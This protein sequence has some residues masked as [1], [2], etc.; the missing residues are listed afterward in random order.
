MPKVFKKAES[1]TTV[2]FLPD[3]SPEQLE[4]IEQTFY[5]GSPKANLRT[6]APGSYVTPD[7]ETAKLM[8]RFHVDTGKTWSDDDLIGKHYFGNQPT[9]KPGKEPTGDATIYK[10]RVAIKKL[11]LLN[12]PY[13]HITLGKLPVEKLPPTFSPDYTP[14]QLKEKLLSMAKL[15]GSRGRAKPT[16]INM[17]KQSDIQ[18]VHYARIK[19]DA[20]RTLLYAELLKDRTNGRWENKPELASKYVE[21]RKET[22]RVYREKLKA[23]GVN[24]PE[25]QS[26]LY[27]TIPGREKFNPGKGYYPHNF[28]INDED[29]KRTLFDVVGLPDKLLHP[30]GPQLGQAGYDDAIARWDKHKKILGK[31]KYMGMTINPRIEVISPHG[32][33]GYANLMKQSASFIPD[34]TPEQLREMEQP[35]EGVRA[36]EPIR[37]LTEREK[38][39]LL[40]RLSSKF[41]VSVH[42]SAPGKRVMFHG[43]TPQRA[44]QIKAKGL[45]IGSEQNSFNNS[46]LGRRDER[47]HNFWTPDLLY[48][49][50]YGAMNDDG[51]FDWDRKPAVFSALLDESSLEKSPPEGSLAFGPVYSADSFLNFANIPPQDLTDVF[52]EKKKA[53]ESSFLP[54]YTPE[55]LKEMGVYKEVYG[56]KDAPRLA[57]LPAW[58]EHWYNEADPHGWLQWY[59]RYSSG[60][61]IEDDKRQIKRWIA[62][63]AR[64]GGK[65]FKDNPTPRRAFALRNWGIDASKLVDDPETLKTVMDEYKTNKYNQK[66]EKVSFLPNTTGWPQGSNG[67]LGK[68][69]EAEFPGVSH[70]FPGVSES[71]R[72]SDSVGPGPNEDLLKRITQITQGSTQESNGPLGKSR[73]AE[74][75][76]VSHKFPEGYKPNYNMPSFLPNK[77]LTTMKKSAGKQAGAWR[78]LGKALPESSAS[79]GKSITPVMQKAL[80]PHLADE[81][82]LNRMIYSL[83]D[84]VLPTG[85]MGEALKSYAAK[86]DGAFSPKILGFALDRAERD[87]KGLTEFVTSNSKLGLKLWA[88]EK[89]ARWYDDVL[90]SM[91]ATGPGH[92]AVVADTMRPGL[93]HPDMGLLVKPLAGHVTHSGLEG[94]S[95][96]EAAPN[97]VLPWIQEVLKK[98]AS[99]EKPGL[100]AN[101]RAKRNRGEAPAKPGDKDY[102]DK[103]QWGKLTK[104]AAELLTK[105]A[106]SPAWQRSEGKNPKGGLNAKGRASYHR[107]TGGTLK[108]PVKDTKAKGESGQR[109]KNFCSRMCGMKKRLTS[110][111]TAR[112]P[113]SRINKSLRAWSCRCAS[114]EDKKASIVDLLKQAD[115]LHPTPFNLTEEQI[116]S[117]GGIP[118][119]ANAYDAVGNVTKKVKNISYQ[120]G[121]K[122]YDTLSD[123]LPKLKNRVSSYLSKKGEQDEIN[124]L[125][126]KGSIKETIGGFFKGEDKGIK[127][128]TGDFLRGDDK[129]LDWRWGM[130]GPYLPTLPVAAAQHAY[131]QTAVFPAWIKATKEEEKVTNILKR[132]LQTKGVGIG[133]NFREYKGPAFDLKNN[134]INLPEYLKNP[135]VLA[136]EAGHALGSKPLLWASAAGKQIGALSVLP[137][138][139]AP[140]EETSR[141]IALGGTAAMVPTL[142]SEIDASI[143]GASLLKRLKVPF[144]GR[145]RAFL[146]IPTYLAAA[147]LP[148]L[149]HLT[150][151]YFGGFE[152]SKRASVLPRAKSAIELNTSVPGET[153]EDLLK[154]ILNDKINKDVFFENAAKH[155]WNISGVPAMIARTVARKAQQNPDPYLRSLRD[156]VSPSTILEVI[157]NN[158]TAFDSV[159]A[160]PL[161]IL[162]PVS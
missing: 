144:S 80:G 6:L 92:R 74:F 55:Q 56:S 148:M 153:P 17:H 32:N 158:A 112:D 28:N 150:K 64:H 22:E 39:F 94:S 155:D 83:K 78:L 102:P 71:R 139:L 136:H 87:V 70:K 89:G 77:A 110:A 2:S 141:T 131:A 54:D 20:L 16:S 48:A 134:F 73:K 15:V 75:P 128:T 62:F 125:L 68:S 51:S 98:T 4:K 37:F 108:A 35:E 122:A 42:N 133:D 12:N 113:D 159:S 147:S 43:T 162:N 5:H 59:S 103:K 60:R 18:S 146:G 138:L 63:K 10:L 142:Y 121:E 126:K 66:M 7:L 120:L 154:R 149:S 86:Y 106:K 46:T 118:E 52:G 47:P 97:L 88:P 111:E 40:D 45:L 151:K 140:N 53:E 81:S 100:W 99:K 129:D 160:K 104:D 145:A 14:E 91:T 34:Y 29:L 127:E 31:S 114:I 93:W 24:V 117:Q 84:V 21:D 57:S 115:Q 1:E 8:G 124:F 105:F 116:R 130:L 67:P 23:I 9:W 58:P 79:V 50:I 109:R 156:K 11:N 107:E 44:E 72:S 82:V 95:L 26:F 143:R 65:A 119:I 13:E 49:Y 157:K 96:F 76:G 41:D 19:H 36:K 3:Y 69:R 90:T 135:S 85:S 123:V 132:F 61:R 161:N 27:S 33:T 30:D 101:I 25:D 38:Q 137:S 152:D